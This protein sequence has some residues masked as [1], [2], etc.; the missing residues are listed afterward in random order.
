MEDS[1][2]REIRFEGKPQK[3]IIELDTSGRVI[4]LCS[5]SKI[6][7]P[8]FRVGWVIGHPEILDKIV[9]AKQTADLCT[10]P[11]VQQIIALY[12]EK[13]LLEKNL[14]KT[15]SLYRSRRSLMLSCFEKYMPGRVTWTKPQ[16]GLFLFVTLPDH[17]D[18]DAILC[19]AI[20]KNVA[21]VAGSTFFCNESGHNTLRIN[22]SYSDE[23]DIEIGVKRLAE[24]IKGEIKG[25]YLRMELSVIIVSFNV[26]EYLK[27]CLVSVQ[28]AARDIDHEILVVDNF[29]YRW[30]S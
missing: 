28:T 2:Y 11:F 13:G 8:G 14:E 24:V 30:I 3:M 17:I 19:K 21:F 5:F 15:I 27:N 26:R 12:M 4:T 20:E 10:S 18:T 6:F 25:Q 1:P 16:G 22:F 7:A 23:K 29:L 9:M